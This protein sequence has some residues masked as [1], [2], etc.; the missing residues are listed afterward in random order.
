MGVPCLRLAAKDIESLWTSIET[1]PRIQVTLDIEHLEV[2]WNGGKKAPA[3]MGD[4]PRKQFVTGQWDATGELVDGLNQV[5]AT[6]KK[7]P[8]VS[9]FV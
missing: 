7:L 6:A 3:S 4:G 9:A 2:R 8:Y 5:R 1:D